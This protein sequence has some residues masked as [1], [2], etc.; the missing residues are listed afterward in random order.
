[1]FENRVGFLS[2]YSS[3]GFQCREG[4]KMSL[5]FFFFTIQHSGLLAPC[6]FI[7]SP[8][9]CKTESLIF[10][11]YFSHLWISITF[12][13]HYFHHCLVESCFPRQKWGWT[14]VGMGFCPL[15]AGYS[16]L[17][18]GASSSLLWK[19]AQ[20]C[21]KEQMPLMNAF[22]HDLLWYLSGCP[23]ELFFLTIP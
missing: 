9:I 1:M 19:R 2:L 8:L 17:Y 13:L 5:F 15:I 10:M 6:S 20:V 7:S 14:S 4:Q 23:S 12:F 22:L 11:M 21:A 3:L 16:V 18:Q